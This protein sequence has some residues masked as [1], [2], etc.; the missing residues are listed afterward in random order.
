MSILSKYKKHK[1]LEKDNTYE[2]SQY[3]E[4]ARALIDYLGKPLTED[5]SEYVVNMNLT[6]EAITGLA[7]ELIR[8]AYSDVYHIHMYP[9][10]KE[11]IYD[12]MGVFLTPDS[13]ELIIIPLDGRINK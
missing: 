8:F 5:S 6:K 1:V 11:I 3:K 4:E 12:Y 9:C 13:E 7:T 2:V 10:I